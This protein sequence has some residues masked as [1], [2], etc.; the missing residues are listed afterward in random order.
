M[1]VLSRALDETLLKEMECPVC[2]QYMVSPIQLCTNG[3]NIC[4]R[5]RESVQFCPTCRAEFSEIRNVAL[6]HIARRQ[7]YPCPNSQSG[8]LQLFS[9]ENIAEHKAVCVY[10]KIKSPFYLFGTCSWN[11]LKNHL[12]EHAKAAHPDY[13][14][15]ESSLHSPYLSEALAI[16]SCF[17]ELFT[18]YLQKRDGRYYAAVQLIGTSGEASKYKCEFTLHAANG[19]EHI[20]KTFLVHGSAENFETI[21]NSGYCFNLDEKTVNIFVE[22]NELNLYINLYTI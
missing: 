2:M 19:I 15:E 20:S 12:K 9:I 7:K 18:Y 1:E 3:H 16:L 5:C 6:E 17:G 13:V 10:G 11:G 21:F 8:C 4:S 22:G 14:L